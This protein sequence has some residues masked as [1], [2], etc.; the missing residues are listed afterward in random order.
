TDLLLI[1]KK[2]D[3]PDRQKL[4][5]VR[6]AAR[7]GADLVSRILTFSMKAEFR[8]RPTDL[9]Q[10]IRRVEELLR[11]TV[12]RMI[13]IDLVLADDLWVIDADSAQIEQ[14][15]LN[16]AVNAQHAMPDGG[17]LVIETS[18]VLLEDDYAR[19]HWKAK[20]GKYVLLTVSDTGVGMK[21]EIVDRIFEPFFTTKANGEGTG[22]GLS[23][24]HG[25]VSQHGGYIRCFSE[26]NRGTS[27]E[28]YLPVSASEQLSDATLT[29]EM[30]A[31]GT[32]T[33]LLVDDD[34]RI[35]EMG[36]QMIELG[37]YQVLTAR[38]GEEALVMY[39]AHAQEI[40]LVILDLI[41]PGMGGK[42]CLQ[43]LL[44][45]DPDVRVLVASGYSSD[46][47][48]MDETITGARGFVRKP[49]D[50]KDIL[51]SIRQ[52]LDRGHL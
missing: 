42:S 51:A 22:L 12:P 10:E 45:I 32:E 35:R 29:M 40:A 18:N 37:G 13:K 2:V 21:S 5:I 3:D 39:A 52:V 15:I 36:R 44:L 4:E 17:R 34:D 26:P 23:M 11:R 50:T 41:M 25:I 20:P 33:V 16:L 14:V 30:P 48:T 1:Q 46:G 8:A 9:N 28:I 49:Y 27:F 43:K 7:D 47:F 31:L 6:Q 19:T 38:S 24:V